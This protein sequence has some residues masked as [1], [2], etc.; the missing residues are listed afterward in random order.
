MRS[1]FTILLGAVLRIQCNL[2]VIKTRHRRIGHYCIVMTCQTWCLRRLESYGSHPQ[3]CPEL[4]SAHTIPPQASKLRINCLITTPTKLQQPITQLLCLK[5]KYILA[6]PQSAA[7][8][9][10]HEAFYRERLTTVA[11]FHHLRTVVSSKIIS[12]S[13]GHNL[14][15]LGS[16][17]NGFCCFGLGAVILVSWPQ[18]CTAESL[19][20]GAPKRPKGITSC[21][22]RDILHKC[23][24][25]LVPHL[26]V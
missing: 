24:L 8:D 4:V 23:P 9:C 25:L 21:L 17:N 26:R 13:G 7:D 16:W 18:S 5:H 12:C 19:R 15:S 1:K 10:S 3:P 14:G 11:E 2:L 20:H 22:P 6:P